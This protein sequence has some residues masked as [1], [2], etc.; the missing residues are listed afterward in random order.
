MQSLL[1]L[2][3]STAISIR[4]VLLLFFSLFS[5]VIL[6]SRS[7]R[8]GTH[9]LRMPLQ[10]VVSAPR[11]PA[12]KTK[13]KK[14]QTKTKSLVNHPTKRKREYTPTCSHRRLRTF[15]FLSRS[16]PLKARKHKIGWGCEARRVEG[17][18][19]REAHNGFLFLQTPCRVPHPRHQPR[20][21][22][23][24]GQTRRGL[25]GCHQIILFHSSSRFPSLHML[26]SQTFKHTLTEPRANRWGQLDEQ[27]TAV[28]GTPTSSCGNS[29]TTA[30]RDTA[31]LH[32]NPSS[33]TSLLAHC[34]LQTATR[35]ARS[36]F[37]P[38]RAFNVVHRRIAAATLHFLAPLIHLLTA[39]LPTAIA[40][41]TSRT[42]TATGSVCI[43]AA[44]VCL[45]RLP[46]FPPW[47]P[48]PLLPL[49]LLPLLP[50]L[51]QSLLRNRTVYEHL[52]TRSTSTW[53]QVQLCPGAHTTVSLF[54]ST[55]RCSKTA[56]RGS[57]T[58]RRAS[59]KRTSLAADGRHLKLPHR[60][61]HRRRRLQRQPNPSCMVLTPVLSSWTT[62]WKC[63]LLVVLQSPSPL[64]TWTWLLDPTLCLK[65]IAL[66]FPRFKQQTAASLR[67]QKLQRSA[68]QEKLKR[69]HEVE[70]LQHR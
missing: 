10:P 7:W 36:N 50:L 41:M 26:S 9:T 69:T 31:Q 4:A 29:L 12:C 35:S 61:D 16:L 49:P 70:Q 53:S 19:E 66:C 59:R 58:C 63:C 65:W 52:Q 47:L 15:G 46:V 68:M 60:A 51:H 17:G 43:K 22:S 37:A 32:V 48:L 2:F 56:R 28:N 25:H 38:R 40:A 8:A 64:S 11:T 55:T 54:K 24:A 44:V 3:I 6:S 42:R 30:A 39:V 13:Q 18:T 33:L 57:S 14:R 62:K 5:P 23:A 27:H 20:P 21:R 67:Y 45:R 34:P 1:P